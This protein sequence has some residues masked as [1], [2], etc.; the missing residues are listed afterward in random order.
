M[1]YENQAELRARITAT[2]G[3]AIKRD[4]QIFEDTS[5]YMN[6]SSGSV[7]RI[8]GHDYYVINDAREGRFGIDDQPKFWVKYTLDLETG[9]RK[10]IKLVFHEEFTVPM[11]FTRIRCLRSPQKESDVLDA[12]AD[13]P[14][15]MQ[16]KSVTDPIGN[17]VRIIDFIPGRSLYRHIEAFEAM[18]HEAYFHETVPGIMKEVIACAEALAELHRRGQHHGD[19]RNDHIIIN[20]ETGLYTWIDFDYQ[21]NYSDYD[22]WSMGNVINMVVGKGTHTVQDA[23][24]IP[25][26]YPHLKNAIAEGDTVLLHK[27]RIANLGKLYPYIPPE[28]N[29]ILMR[30][31]LE[32]TNFYTDLQSQ[33]NDLKAVFC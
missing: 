6:I 11:G 19:V 16:G 21:V 14:R 17:L 18:P 15:F 7:L 8:G 13:H 33:V 31:S 27:N 29:A 24:K 26:K 12:V 28:L 3:R 23:E 1:I 20:K 10:V 4:V 5:S 2:T 9:E 30:F 25:A 22:C 32:A